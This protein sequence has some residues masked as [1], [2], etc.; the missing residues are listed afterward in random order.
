MWILSLIMIFWISFKRREENFNKIE[1]GIF[2]SWLHLLNKWLITTTHTKEA[3]SHADINLSSHRPWLDFHFHF[4]DFLSTRRRWEIYA[5]LKFQVGPI[6]IGN[7]SYAPRS[8]SLNFLTIRKWWEKA[9]NMFSNFNDLL[10]SVYDFSLGPL[11]HYNKK[12]N[13]EVSF[14]FRNIT[15]ND[16][17]KK[18]EKIIIESVKNE[19]V[20][21][22]SSAVIEKN[23]FP[24]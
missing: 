12:S 24:S 17:I 23:F 3:S 14:V 20:N 7:S 1:I 13:L 15:K 6:N 11:S 18:I 2:H 21:S 4:D 5:W 16:E 22:S 9:R 10:P 8:L 19:E